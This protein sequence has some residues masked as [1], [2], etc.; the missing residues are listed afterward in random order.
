MAA[1]YR[2]LLQTAPTLFAAQTRTVGG[3]S[4]CMARP[5]CDSRRQQK[6]LLTCFPVSIRLRT[7]KPCARTPSQELTD[8][9]PSSCQ[10]RLMAPAYC[11]HA[12]T[13]KASRMQRLL[14]AASSLMDRA[15]GAITLN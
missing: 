13:A 8:H 11:E 4:N 6:Q 9:L 15:A 14:S 5:R 7:Q 3:L 1:S 2:L 12:R 10:L